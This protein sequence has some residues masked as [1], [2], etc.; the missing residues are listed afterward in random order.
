MNLEYSGMYRRVVKLMLT[1]VS[2]VR[3]VSIIIALMME[4]AR[5]RETLVSINLTTRHYIEE[6]S[7][8]H[9]RRRENFKSH[10]KIRCITGRPIWCV[11]GLPI[12]FNGGLWY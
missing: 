9:T 5:T 12:V 2:E 11:V 3:T 1:N 4:A 6:D 7:K 8:L 10:I